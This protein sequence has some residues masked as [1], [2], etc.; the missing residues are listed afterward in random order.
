MNTNTILWTEIWTW[1]FPT[2][3]AFAMMTLWSRLQWLYRFVDL[4]V[5]IKQPAVHP[6]NLHGLVSSFFY[7]QVFYCILRSGDIFKSATIVTSLLVTTSFTISKWSSVSRVST[8]V[9]SPRWI[10]QVHHLW[11]LSIA[12][13]SSSFILTVCSCSAAYS[14]KEPLQ[15]QGTPPA[16]NTRQW[17]FRESQY[18][19]LKSHGSLDLSKTIWFACVFLD[20]FVFLLTSGSARKLL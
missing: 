14:F 19:S 17:F 10:L 16:A 13:L 1:H 11:T 12:H 3:R 18:S 4:H 7:V 2:I 8:K 9:A 5:S 15:Q 6:N 20:Y